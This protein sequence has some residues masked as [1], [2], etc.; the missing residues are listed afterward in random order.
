MEGRSE[1]TI[2]FLEECFIL[3]LVFQ[4]NSSK[5]SNFHSA[6]EPDIPVLIVIYIFELV[7]DIQ[8]KI[9]MYRL[10]LTYHELPSSV[11]VR[12]RVLF[13]R[14]VTSNNCP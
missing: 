12:L 7:N 11:I 5:S 8:L 2:F 1:Q 9:Y 10:Q 13:W 6:R 3:T 14:G 4:L